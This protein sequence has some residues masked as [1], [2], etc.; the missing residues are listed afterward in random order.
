MSLET[1]TEPSTAPTAA[2]GSTPWV[3][4]ITIAAIALAVFIAVLLLAGRQPEAPGIDARIT[5]W[6]ALH[7]TD[8]EGQVGLLLARL[9]TPVV[10][11]SGTVIAAVIMWLRR[12]RYEAVVLAVS[13]AVAYGVGALTKVAVHRARPEAPFNLAPESEGSFPSGHVIVIA[14]IALVALVLA[15]RH[16][17]ATG[18]VVASVSAFLVV[19]AIA[20][21][22]LLVGAHWFTDLLAS[23][24]LATLIA[25]GAA[26]AMARRPTEG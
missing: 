26:I 17:H 21:D 19:A 5:E 24:A 8:G 4:L 25:V 16:L 13:V 23:L 14:T 22:R 20:L 9:T 15:W 12:L 2:R 3:A 18:R 11:I 1:S 7:R 6:F 10:L